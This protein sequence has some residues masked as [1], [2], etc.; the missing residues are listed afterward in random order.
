MRR[1]GRCGRGCLSGY[2]NVMCTWNCWE[3]WTVESDWLILNR[4]PRFQISNKHNW[5]S[6]CFTTYTLKSKTLVQWF[7]DLNMCQSSLDDLLKHSTASHSTVPSPS[8]LRWDPR[9][10][11]LRCSWGGWSGSTRWDSPCEGIDKS[12][13]AQKWKSMKHKNSSQSMHACLVTQSC[14][15]LCNPV[16]C[17]PPGSPVLGILW[18]R[19]LEWV[20]IPFSRGSSQPQE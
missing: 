14:P 15:V 5:N 11:I 9:M 12:S 20:A 8:D 7:P 13:H 10:C 18:A 19:T 1:R 2:P 16:D 4:S 3:S 17:S 6:Y